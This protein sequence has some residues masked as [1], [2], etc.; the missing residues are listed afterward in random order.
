MSALFVRGKDFE[1][2]EKKVA[3]LEARIDQ[4]VESQKLLQEQNRNTRDR[5]ERLV[6]ENE[7]LKEK[8]N[9]SVKTN[10]NTNTRKDGELRSEEMIQ[11]AHD[12][13]KEFLRP[14][15]Q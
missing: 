5:L 7:T 12:A 15:T 1:E 14:L 11:K 13:V 9:A 6:Q 4:L 10:A 3:N 2:L 8:V